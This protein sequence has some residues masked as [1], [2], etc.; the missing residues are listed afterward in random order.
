MDYRGTHGGN[1]WGAA[2]EEDEQRMAIDV[3]TKDCTAV[4]DAELAEMADMCA[5]GPNPF[6]VGLLS[7]QTEEWVLISTARENGKLRGFS[8][9]T[10]ERIGGTP[11]VLVGLA[12]VARTSKRST[13]LRQITEAQLHRALM[14]FPDEDV[15]MGTQF[16]NA[17]GFDAFKPLVDI[18]PRPGHKASGEER[19]WGRR[20]AKRFNIGASRYLDRDF[21]VVGNDSQA[22]LLDY[23]TAKPESIDPDVA[24]LFDKVDRG[25]GDTMIAFG[26]IMAEDLLKYA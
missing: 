7:K 1:L 18:V 24:G 5:D 16:D 25:G 2:N 26:W 4:T 19:A 12:S 8:F 11:S 17:G 21:R 14:A 9:S 15:L 6:S 20:L 13:V 3:E 22:C 10:L 23:E